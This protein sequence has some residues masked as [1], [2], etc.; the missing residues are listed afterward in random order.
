MLPWPNATDKASVLA[1]IE[2]AWISLNQAVAGLSE[3]RM[4]SAGP[5]GWTIKDHLAHI[6]AWNLSLVALLE[7]RHRQAALDLEGFSTT[8]WDG[9]NQVMLRRH[10]AL[11]PDEVRALLDGSRVMVLKVLGRLTDADLSRPYRDY[12]PQDERTGPLTSDALAAEIGRLTGSDRLFFYDSISPI[13]E[14]D[15]I[16][17][18][19][20]FRASRYGKS[21]D[22]TD[23]YIN[24]PFATSKPSRRYTS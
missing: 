21:L 18:S 20:A 16:D 12:Q 9:Q 22:G 10:R 7:R 19:V 14:A 1:R 13:V 3:E 11:V 4:C 2:C 23:D 15:S 6:A 17:M 24:C 5:D 8:D